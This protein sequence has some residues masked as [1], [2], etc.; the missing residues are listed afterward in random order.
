MSRPSEF[1]GVPCPKCKKKGL[2]RKPHPHAYGFY[3]SNKC[4]CRFCF[5]VFKRD[6][7]LDAYVKAWREAKP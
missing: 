4:Q 2:G 7:K 6:E 1:A 5:A 3:E